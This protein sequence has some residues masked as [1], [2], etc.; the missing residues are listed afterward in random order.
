MPAPSHREQFKYSVKIMNPAKKSDHSV[1]KFTSGFFNM[2][3]ELKDMLHTSFS[4][5]LPELMDIQVGYIVPGHGLRGKQEWLCEDS[6]LNEMYAHYGGKRDVLLWCFPK[7]SVSVQS[8]KRGRTQSPKPTKS[9]P[10]DSQ[11]EKDFE[12]QE[13]LKKLKGKHETTYSPEQLHTWANLIQMKK[14]LSLDCPPNYPFFRGNKKQ[15]D[16]GKGTPLKSACNTL[17]STA[18]ASPSKRLSMRSELINQLGKCVNLLE[19]GALSEDEY[20]ELQKSIM[21]DIKTVSLRK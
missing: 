15:S 19:K 11:R 16:Q 5:K 9:S 1:E 6:D 2:I 14:H 8:R 13:I 18:E 10:Y 3:Q 21:T 4:E 20:Q 7:A 12:V 17:G